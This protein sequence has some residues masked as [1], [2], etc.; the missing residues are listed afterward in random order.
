[1]IGIFPQG[2]R[3]PGVDPSLT[4]LKSGVGMLAHRS[5]ATVVPVFISTKKYRTRIFHRTDVYFGK[6]I[7]PD[8]LAVEKGN[9][10]QY[11]AIS[12]KIFGAICQMDPHR[13][14]SEN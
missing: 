8:E 4:E 7:T 11:T 5:K 10:A 14:T 12:Q 9:A 1:M 6:P 3:H 13:Q 2:T